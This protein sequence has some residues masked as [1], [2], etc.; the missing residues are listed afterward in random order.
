[1]R[2]SALVLCLA[3]AGA[4]LSAGLTG[5]TRGSTSKRPPVHLNPNMDDQPKAQAQEASAFFAD[6]AAMR[7]P[8]EGTVARG[9]LI[10]SQVG[11]PALATGRDAAGE[12]VAASPLPVDQA[13]LA[14]GAERYAIYCSPCHGA[15]GDGQ[16]MLRERAGVN[17]ANLLQERLRAA[18]DGYLFDVVTHGFGLMPSYAYQIP[19]RDRWAIVAHVREL[20]GAG[21]A[22]G[23]T[24]VPLESASSAQAA[25]S[26]EEAP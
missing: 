23:P 10:E 8:V 18:G 17:T 13:V 12:L 25:P 26:T 21:D 24:E 6:G 15:T 2:L 16:S 11:D 14:R 1:M 19:V 4:V 9:A 5:C 3:A 22:S 7:R 20:Q